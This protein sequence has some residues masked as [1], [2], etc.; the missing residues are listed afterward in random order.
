MC[1]TRNVIV[2]IKMTWLFSDVFSTIFMYCDLNISANTELPET[3]SLSHFKIISSPLMWPLFVRK[4]FV[5]FQKNLFVTA[6][7]LEIPLKC[8][9]T[10]FLLR[11]KY[12]FLCIL[13][14]FPLSLVELWQNLFLNLFLV[15][16]AQPRLF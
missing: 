4:D 12:L 13:Y 8:F 7:S 6:P 16:G 14:F 11:D 5:M 15:S 3:V 1:S 10:L 2:P 9:L